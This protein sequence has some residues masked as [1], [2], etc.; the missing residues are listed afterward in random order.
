M[1][2]EVVL[3]EFQ[4]KNEEESGKQSVEEDT[5]QI[6]PLISNSALLVRRVKT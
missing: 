1:K 5:N 3:V 6:H 4:W 2:N